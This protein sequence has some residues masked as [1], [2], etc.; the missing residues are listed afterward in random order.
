MKVKVLKTFLN[1]YFD[2]K[3]IEIKVKS[4]NISQIKFNWTLKERDI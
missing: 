1:N 4:V 3:Y 2:Y